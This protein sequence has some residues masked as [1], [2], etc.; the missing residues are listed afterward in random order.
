MK[1]AKASDKDIAAL[2]LFFQELEW[3][4]ENDEY[5][6][7]IFADKIKESCEDEEFDDAGDSEERL[8]TFIHLWWP[9]LRGSWGRVVHGCDTL[10]K[11]VCDPSQ[12]VLDWKPE[13]KAAL[14]RGGYK[15]Q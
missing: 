7:S 15:G 13:L 4:V 14:E 9:R 1:T 12:N 2:N 3:A 8:A 6:D 5:S 11:N 10:I